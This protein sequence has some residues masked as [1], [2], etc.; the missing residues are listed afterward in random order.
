MIIA[1]PVFCRNRIYGS[2][3]AQCKA[4]DYHLKHFIIRGRKSC[5]QWEFERLT[6]SYVIKGK[7]QIWFSPVFKTNKHTNKSRPHWQRSLIINDIKNIIW[8][9]LLK[10]EL[11]KRCQMST[12]VQLQQRQSLSQPNNTGLKL[13]FQ[14]IAFHREAP[15]KEEEKVWTWERYHIRDV[16]DHCT[17]DFGG[18]W[19]SLELERLKQ[20]RYLWGRDWGWDVQKFFFAS[21]VFVKLLFRTRLTPVS[22][23]YS[24]VVSSE[25]LREHLRCELWRRQV[26]PSC[27]HLPSPSLPSSTLA[28]KLSPLPKVPIVHIAS[29][30]ST[31]HLHG[32]S[33]S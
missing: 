26:L 14:L 31:T 1:F 20:V 6:S 10:L 13:R 18:A 33:Q 24:R 22:F 25:L 30:L 19:I 29:P 16:E 15:M 9:A 32:C 12:A 17:T 27:W 28:S 2:W 21:K 7:V 4:V 3:C 23:A 11:L 5:N 8:F